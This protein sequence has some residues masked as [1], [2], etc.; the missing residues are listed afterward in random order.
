[1]SDTI[2]GIN[3]RNLW[4]I[5]K[6]NPRKLIRFVDNKYKL[7]NYL[8]ERG[9]PVP[10]TLAYLTNRKQ[11][12]QYDFGLFG[13]TSFVAK[14]NKWSKGK[15]IFIV[16]KVDSSE[17]TRKLWF[18]DR[19]QAWY[20]S[21][22]WRDIPQYSYFFRNKWI[23][24]ADTDFK[25]KLLPI[26]EWNYTLANRPDTILVEEKLLPWS[27]F[28]EFCKYGLADIRV[29]VCNLV[30]VAAMLRMPTE[31]SGGVA[32]LAQWW[33]ALGIDIAT[34]TII[35]LWTKSTIYKT[36]FP[37][38]YEHLYKKK[39]PFWDDVL[40][41][42]ANAQYFVN[43]WYV[44]LDWVITRDWPKL[45]EVNGKAWLEI[46]N[47]TLTPLQRLLHK[48]YDL[49]ITNPTKWVEIAKSL[50]ETRKTTSISMN[51]VMFLSQKWT[52]H[53]SVDDKQETQDVIAL[54]KTNRKKS[55]ASSELISLIEKAKNIS[56]SFWSNTI[57]RNIVL[58]P[59]DNIYSNRIE[60]GTND[61]KGYYVKPVHRSHPNIK[62]LSSK[63]ILDTE[64][65]DIMI[66]D[67]N[68]QEIHRK[69]V[70]SKRLYP[71]NY[72]D[73]LDK[74]ITRKG[75]YNPTFSYT[76]PN[77]SELSA[78]QTAI[79]QLRDEYSWNNKL[80]SNFAQLHYEKISE[81]ENKRALLQ[82]LTKQDYSSLLQANIH[83]YGD[84]N[85]D[86]VKKSKVKMYD[87]QI[88]DISGWDKKISLSRVKEI[89]HEICK[90]YN[91]I[92]YD[93]KTNSLLFSRISI[94]WGMRP[95][96]NINPNGA[97][98]EY[99]LYAQL[100]H[101][102]GTHLLRSRNGRKTKWNILHRWTANYLIDEE[103][104]AI[105]NA[106]NVMKTY[107][108]S[109]ENIKIY[110]KYYLVDY[111]QTH[112]FKELVQKIIEIRAKLGKSYT[113]SGVFKTALKLKRGIKRTKD[114]DPGAVYF[115]DK[116]YL[117]GYKK[118]SEWIKDGND[119]E[120]LMIGKIKIEDLERL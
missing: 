42:S 63:S 103:W 55:Y 86:L 96:I 104:L 113:Y 9:I 38:E 52:L 79:K 82:A 110:Q 51:K 92:R 101:E 119:I 3:K 1:M 111:A 32:N 20:R 114:I 91:I 62:I 80:Q 29:I 47:I 5:K 109:F 25:A 46:Q 102:I 19:Y 117:E 106:Q 31:K 105:Y 64:L 95:V 72:L 99:E 116:I 45:L 57:L 115:K 118:I 14:P 56:F 78:I 15:G 61:L 34:W 53:Y 13:N 2:L 12:L 88:I 26:L 21:I 69:L 93:I 54:V 36:S 74:F 35:T 71:T 39:I 16:D 59:S 24:Y 49:D 73:Q 107:S 120:R 65:D 77:K 48:I 11:L 90:K 4:Y 23:I 27:G 84:I 68:I 75:N 6:L 37:E 70:L 98:K 108:E 83:L 81:F 94:W 58:Y 67:K 44:W 66:L 85:K 18:W 50:F 60:L 89:I 33:I 112:D 8:Q 43:L 10:K 87:K 7:K 22:F 28:E 100:E 17:Y 40:M 97:W 30:P 41:F 76:F